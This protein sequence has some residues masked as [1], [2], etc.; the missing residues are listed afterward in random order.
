MEF[1]ETKGDITNGAVDIIV[2]A[3][4]VRLL[5]GGGVS[6]AIHAKAGIELYEECQKIGTCEYGQA[7]ITNGYNLLA[8]HVIHTTTPIRGQHNGNEGKLLLSCYMESLK[9]ANIN[10]AITIAFPALGSGLHNM[11]YDLTLEL[12]KQAFGEFRDS[13]P[14]STIEK[15]Y[16]VHFEPEFCYT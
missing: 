12:A 11:P 6:G 3:A 2:N 10:H 4:N 1:V 16:F 8:K 15:V 9:L 5:A 14:E 13:H 7:V